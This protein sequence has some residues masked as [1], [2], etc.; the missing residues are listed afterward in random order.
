MPGDEAARN[1]NSIDIRQEEASAP[2]GRYHLLIAA[3]IA[4]VVFFDSYG[5]FN[6]AYVMHYVVRPWHLS[7][8]EAGFLVSSGL[9]GFMLGALTQGAFSDRY[10]RRPVLLAALWIATLFSAATAVFADSFLSFCTLRFCMGVGLG[11]LLPLG[12]TYM[13]EFAPLR[14]RNTFSTW[15]W[16]LGFNSGG[17]FASI[18][19]L[20]FTPHWGWQALYY[21][22]SVSFLVVLACHFL[23]PESVQFA[24][25]HHR[26]EEVVQIL[27]R[28]NP[29]RRARY[30]NP[31]AVFS[32]EEPQEANLSLA[33]LISPANRRLTLATWACC[34][35]LLFAIYGLN[36]WVPTALLQ[37]GETFLASFAAGAILQLM[38]FIGTLLCSVLADRTG[39]YR[40]A[41]IAWFCGGAACVFLLAAF[42][43]HALNLACV[44]GAGFCLMGGQGVL[45]N[46]TAAQYPTRLRSTA[47]GWMLGV[48]RAGA[49]LGPFVTG[50]IQQVRPGWYPLFIAIALSALFSALA[51]AI[52]LPRDAQRAPYPGRYSAPPISS[53]PA[54][55]APSSEECAARRESDRLVPPRAQS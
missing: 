3:L 29:A 43:L 19:G 49:I 42:N 51:I 47:V 2:I 28:L 33:W 12:V 21:V 22:G 25:S 17:A 7:P 48:G 26:R 40:K 16:T 9:I 35:F 44:A 1:E 4:A 46:Y 23:L 8:S 15:G 53:A 6:A 31:A 36:G 34:F 11:A 20:L 14:F 52:V 37:R 24:G 27:R 18:V 55:S 50:V 38:A 45:N 32:I 39:D 30:D 10:G 41:M 54:L 5:T 13:N